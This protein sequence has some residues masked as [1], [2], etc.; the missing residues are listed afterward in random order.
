MREELG[1]C[2][3]CRQDLKEEI[4]RESW[5]TLLHC[6][7]GHYTA[8]KEAFFGRWIAFNQLLEKISEPLDGLSLSEELL[9]DLRK[10]NQIEKE[11]PINEENKREGNDRE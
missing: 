10:M 9:E 4:G 3:I 8:K 6:P 1:R 5:D 2:P 7:A 11:D